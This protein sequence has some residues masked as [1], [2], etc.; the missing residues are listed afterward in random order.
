M[1]AP[2]AGAET[3]GKMGACVRGAGWAPAPPPPQ[4]EPGV[5]AESLC[6]LSLCAVGAWA[7]LPGLPRPGSTRD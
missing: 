4:V 3:A 2:T 6:A 7:S 5:H 1:A